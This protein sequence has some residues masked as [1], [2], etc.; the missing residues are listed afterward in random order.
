MTTVNKSIKTSQLH[1]VIRQKSIQMTNAK[2]CIHCGLVF[3]LLGKHS[4][5]C[6]MNPE[7]KMQNGF[8]TCQSCGIDIP[9]KNHERHSV[10]C[11][12]IAENTVDKILQSY[13]CEYLNILRGG[14]KATKIDRSLGFGN[15]AV[16]EIVRANVENDLHAR[17]M[18]SDWHISPILRV[19]KP[20]GIEVT[21]IAFEDEVI[22]VQS[23]D[24]ITAVV[25]LITDERTMAEVLNQIINLATYK[26][27][28]R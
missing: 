28:T 4:S 18:S 13:R 3:N 8:K 5:G 9:G 16:P 11:D 20:E 21:E 6:I 23:T 19:I 1:D 10:A 12:G 22:D 17:G 24:A 25:D 26:L 27:A 2:I 7:R 14:A 15:R